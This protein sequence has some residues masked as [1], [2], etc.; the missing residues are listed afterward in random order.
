VEVASAGAEPPAPP[1]PTVT[2]AAVGDILLDRGVGQKIE[3][4]GTQYPF[5]QVAPI[6][7]AADITFGNLECPLAEKGR[8]VIKPFC[9]KARP[10]TVKSLLNAGFD[11]LS[12]ANNHT[13][14]CGRTGLV[15]T[16]ALLD[17]KGIRWCGAGRTL[18]E[19]ER[20]AVLE[21]KGLRIAF[22]GF[23]DFLPEGSFLVEKRPTIAFANEK[24]VRKAVAAAGK[25]ADVVVASFHW[26]VEYASR[27]SR[28]QEAIARA[29]VEAGADLVLGHHPHVLQGLEMV[30][31][32]AGPGRR[33]SLIAYSLGNF[34]FDQRRP[35]TDQSAI[36]RCT[37]GREGVLDAGVVP[38]RL[39][40]LRPRPAT[41]AEAT[42]ILGRL[43]RTSAERKTTLVDGEIMISPPGESDR[44]RRTD[45][46]GSAGPL[47][48]A[49]R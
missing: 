27:P 38:I 41:P 30:E 49:F 18:E 14:D 43:A 20:A 32:K 1:P 40:H 33:P 7:S 36:L 17:R 37:L 25:D 12:L 31:R 8:K 44:P 3:Q 35:P 47:R 5:E 46:P 6:L 4:Y 24:R 48:P 34:V 21:V 19:A 29:A 23:C 42:T 39:E 15:E 26:G 16:M 9:F 10:V 13:M 2:L 28:R 22:V 11:L 45:L